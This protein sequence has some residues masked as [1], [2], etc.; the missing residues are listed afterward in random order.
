MES[1]PLSIFNKKT[2][3]KRE[4]EPL[5]GEIKKI[6]RLNEIPCIFTFAVASS[7]KNT[8]YITDG[9]PTGSMGLNLVE[10]RF[11]NYLVALQKGKRLV[12]ADAN[13]LEPNQQ[14]YLHD[15]EE[16]YEDSHYVSAVLNSKDTCIIF[17]GN[18][19]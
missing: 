12:L 10:D 9:C 2:L 11:P 1:K 15:A 18:I 8:E 5:V 3:Y 7:Q 6:C 19:E 17:D 4:I 16:D 14:E 13:S